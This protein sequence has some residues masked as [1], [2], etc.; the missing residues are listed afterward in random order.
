MLEILDFNYR[1]VGK[2]SLNNK[3]HSHPHHYEILHICSGTGVI[4]VNDHLFPI[5]RNT[6]VF[7]N[8]LDVH[9]SVPDTPTE[10]M[11]SKLVIS[12]SFIE[13][14][15]QLTGASQITQ[16]L[17]VQNSG[18]CIKLDPYQVSMIDSEMKK[19]AAHITKE[20]L[21][22]KTNIMLSVFKIL[23]FAYE[24]TEQDTPPLKNKM[25][26]I[27][28]YLSENIDHKITLEELCQKFCMSKCYMCHTFKKT[29]GM[30]IFDYI[31]AT[32]ISIAKRKLFYTDAPLSDIALSTGFSSF[33]YFSKVFK[34]FEGISPRKFR[35]TRNTTP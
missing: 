13:S 23:L 4:M 8:G 29:T 18:L 31:L 5:Q 16:K 30:T 35:D 28:Q 2:D 11:R 12:S 9:C 10:Y 7:I 22:A 24:N 15:A 32:R 33:S 20:D 17:F 34:E 21:G 26:D 25:A 6:I 1:E 27:M 3:K 14:I 19:I